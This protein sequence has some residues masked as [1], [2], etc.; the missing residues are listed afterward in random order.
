M[1]KL[2]TVIMALSFILGGY[3]YVAEAHDGLHF[4]CSVCGSHSHGSIWHDT[5]KDGTP[6]R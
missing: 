3:L 2:L 5:D 6:D 4:H 1:K